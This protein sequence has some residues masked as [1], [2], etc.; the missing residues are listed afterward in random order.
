[1]LT[2]FTQVN[3]VTWMGL[4]LYLMWGAWVLLLGWAA[5]QHFQLQLQVFPVQVR[6]PLGILARMV[7]QLVQ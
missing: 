5:L 4:G 1:M 2:C 3:S 7:L 6:S